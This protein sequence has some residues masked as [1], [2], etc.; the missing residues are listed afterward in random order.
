MSLSSYRTTLL[1]LQRP[2]S[3]TDE[4]KKKKKKKK[5]EVRP[6]RLDGSIDPKVLVSLTMG[7]GRPQQQQQQQRLSWRTV[8]ILY[9]AILGVTQFVRTSSAFSPTTTTWS[10][11]SARD[12][13]QFGNIR[14]RLFLEFDNTD[15]TNNNNEDDSDFMASLRSRLTQVSDQETKMPIV[16][17]DPIVPRQVMKIE[18]VNDIPFLELIKTRITQEKPTFG[19]VGMA[20]LATTGQ[21]L[22][23]QNGV[24]V[25]IVGKPQAVLAQDNTKDKDTTSNNDGRDDTNVS[26]SSLGN[27]LRLELKAKRRFR[28]TGEFSTSPYGWSEARVRFLDSQQ[29]ER[30]EESSY[31]HPP[32]VRTLD[33]NDSS[34]QEDDDDDD[35][36]VVDRMSLARAMSRAREFTSPNMQYGGQSLVDRWIELARQHEHTPG[37]IDQLLKDIGPIPSEDESPSERAFWIGALINPLPGMGVAMEIRPQLLMARTAEERV[38]VA[39]QGLLGSIKHMDGT[40]PLF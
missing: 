16:A 22:P 13:K 35:D 8:G 27:G 15:N 17:L 34:P 24:E 25:E 36:T 40:E 21:T 2:V 4:E 31:N 30:E 33:D 20:T 11:G 6:V 7:K 26:S 18:V 5:K 39:R 37:Q 1:L 23:L 19:M 10:C 12:S 28:I 3:R 32:S 9:L 29:E 38:L 14:T